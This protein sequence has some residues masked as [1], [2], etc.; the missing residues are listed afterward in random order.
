M[1]SQMLVNVVVWNMSIGLAMKIVNLVLNITMCI[2]TMRM[3]Q[4]KLGGST[5]LM[6]N[7]QLPAGKVKHYVFGYDFLAGD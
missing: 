7:Y 5:N 4:L 3:T 2:T 1:V 6:R